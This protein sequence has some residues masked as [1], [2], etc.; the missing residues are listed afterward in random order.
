M[1][2]LAESGLRGL[3]NPNDASAA[4]LVTQQLGFDHDSL[5]I[6]QQRTSWGTAQQRLD[7]V[8][9][10]NLLIDRVTANPGW[11]SS[12][13]WSLAQAVQV[14]AFDGDPRPVN[15][16]SS[17]YGGNYRAELPEAARLARLITSDA[18]RSSCRGA[19]GSGLGESPTGPVGPHGLPSDYVIPAASAPARAAVLAALA[20]LGK[21][22]VFGSVGPASFDCSGLTQWAWARAGVPLAH[23]TGDQFAAGAPTDAGHLAPGDLVLTP[24]SD[25]TPADPQHVGLYIGRGLVVEAPQTGDVVK[26]VTYSSFVSGGLSGLRHIG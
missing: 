6:F 10:T 17:V 5:G 20:E 7:P 25:G 18:A 11:Q 3:G 26:V 12:D 13:P 15:H 14:S 2:G 4:G 1:I 16:F 21:P 22:Y 24:G 9:S 8:A 23:Y 19:G